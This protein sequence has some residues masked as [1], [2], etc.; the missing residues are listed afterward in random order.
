MAMSVTITE[1]ANGPNPQKIKFA[2]TSSAGGIATSSAT[3]SAYTGV[4]E[5]VHFIPGTG[6][7]TPTANYDVTLTDEDGVDVLGG[8]G[9]NRSDTVPEILARTLALN[10]GAV[11]DD[12]LT[13]NVSGAGDTKKGTVLVFI[14]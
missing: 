6:G 2:W 4:I 12:R 11:K 13:L 5:A 8:S 14:R 7:D 3:N 9:E 1:E 10:L